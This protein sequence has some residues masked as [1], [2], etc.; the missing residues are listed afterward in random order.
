M[1]GP[2]PFLRCRLTEGAAALSGAGVL[3][4]EGT[5][6]LQR[7]PRPGALVGWLLGAERETPVYD[8]SLLLGLPP[9]D[10]GEAAKVVLYGSGP[11]SCGLLVAAASPIPGR[12]LE[13]LPRPALFDL[14]HPAAWPGVIASGGELI[15]WV[16]PTSLDGALAPCGAGLQPS[17]P[18]RRPLPLHNGVSKPALLVFPANGAAG[19]AGPEAA[20]ALSVSQV[21]EVVDLGEPSPFP[22]G[23]DFLLGLIPWRGRAVP[24]LDLALALGLPAGS[25]AGW[26]YALIARTADPSDC[27][28]LAASGPVAMKRLPLEGRVIEAPEGV[29]PRDPRALVACAEIDGR[30]V[31]LPDLARILRPEPAD[32][33]LPA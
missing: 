14:V 26:R 21:I 28:A 25:R 6:L 30:I 5:R 8:L 33:G 23:P 10:S 32:S 1:T 18:P 4:V 11:A 12:T 13:V 31:F 2:R 29:A 20:L 27:V 22:G 7:L 16:D 24:L 3:G 17:P 9:A 15:P 19:A